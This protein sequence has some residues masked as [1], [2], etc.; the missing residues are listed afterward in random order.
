MARLVALCIMIAMYQLVECRQDRVQGSAFFNHINTIHVTQK[1]WVITFQLEM[2]QYYDWLTKLRETLDILRNDVNGMRPLL[3]NEVQANASTTQVYTMLET[4]QLNELKEMY[5]KLNEARKYLDSLEPLYRGSHRGMNRVKRA[6]IPFL[7]DVL[8]VLFGTAT[9]SQLDGIKEYLNELS[10]SD[11]EIRHIVDKSIS[12][13]NHTSLEVVSNRRAINRIIDVTD[14]LVELRT[15]WMSFQHYTLRHMQLQLNLETVRN[16]V[17]EFVHELGSLRAKLTHAVQGH[18]TPHLLSPV[19]LRDVIMQIHDH[20]GANIQLPFSQ[21]EPLDRYYKVLKCSM[22]PTENGFLFVT[23]VPLRDTVSEFEVYGIQTV[24]I[25]FQNSSI[26]TRYEL[27]EKYFAISVDR[28]RVTFLDVFQLR[29]CMHDSLR[30]CPISSPIYTTAS[31]Q[32]NCAMS[33]FLNRDN[34]AKVCKALVSVSDVPSPAAVKVKKGSWVITTHVPVR[35]TRVCPQ[36]N[37]QTVVIN[38]PLG[39]VTLNKGC[40]ASSD[41]LSLPTEYEHMSSLG[42]ISVN[43]SIPSLVAIWEPVYKL[44]NRSW[45]EMPTKLND[46]VSESETLDKLHS[47]LSKHV[48]NLGYTWDSSHQRTLGLIIGICVASVVCLMLLLWYCKC[49]KQGSCML[50]KRVNR[51]HR[52]TTD[53]EHASELRMMDDGNEHGDEPVMYDEPV[54]STVPKVGSNAADSNVP[55]AE[56]TVR[57]KRSSSTP[58][59]PTLPRKLPKLQVGLW[60]DT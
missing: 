16:S 2:S 29:V 49:C 5:V 1:S 58:L 30:F 56:S 20:L 57:P 26:V 33:L 13:L 12:V 45:V 51:D 11:D 10:Q 8:H 3:V 39:V 15:Q 6:A 54:Y 31:L 14:E 34:V 17:N 25:P 18:V 41:Y 22:I 35:F 38:P 59:A 24:P 60:P 28:T 43:I 7:G 9:S 37:T 19:K 47:A 46:L 4:G 55:V 53:H 23:H 36:A 27:K 21:H 48:D 40:H 50:V 52:P 44:M 32:N 42:P